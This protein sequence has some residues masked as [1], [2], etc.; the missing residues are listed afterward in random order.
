MDV[1]VITGLYEE[2]TALLDATPQC[3]WETKKDDRDF[4]YHVGWLPTGESPLGI[5]AAWAGSMGPEHAVDA[6]RALTGILRPQ[7]IAMCGI[8]AGREG[9]VFL[10]DVIV[11]NRVFRYDQ[12]KLNV[13]T[14]KGYE[15]EELLH[16]LETHNLKRSWRVDASYF[17]DEGLASELGELRP[18]SRLYQRTWVLDALLLAETDA[19]LHP[20][21]SP[22]RDRR[23]PRW[24]DVVMSLLD[25]DLCHVNELGH[26]GLTDSGRRIAQRERVVRP[27]GPRH[28]PSLRVHV[29]PIATGGTKRRDPG[30]F[31]RIS[32]LN[33]KVLGVEME[34][35]SIGLVAENS[36]LRSLVV[37]AVSD[38]GGDEPQEPEMRLF[39][40]TASARFLVAFLS[41]LLRSSR[42]SRRPSRQVNP[43]QDR[44]AKPSDLATV[45]GVPLPGNLLK[46]S[47]VVRGLAM[48]RFLHVPTHWGPAASSDRAK[49]ANVC[50]VLLGVDDLVLREPSAREAVQSGIDWLLTVE[51]DGAFPS[52]SRDLVTTQ[53]TALASIA[54]LGVSGCWR[55]SK[56]HRA[57]SATLA[58]RA[59]KAC[60]HLAGERGWGTWEGAS[61]RI[62][63]TLWALIALALQREAASAEW[64]GQV[65]AAHSLGSPGRFGFQPGTEPRISPT[66]SFLLLVS[67]S[68]AGGVVPADS[69][70]FGFELDSA[71]E[72]LLEAFRAEPWPSSEREVYYVDPQ[73]RGYVGNVEQWSW[74]HTSGAL[75]LA[76]LALHWDRVRERSDMELVTRAAATLC[77]RM[78][79]GWVRDPALDESGLPDAIFPTAYACAALRILE[80]V[81]RDGLGQVK[82]TVSS[83]K[84]HGS[85]I[86]KS[87]AAILKEGALLLVR[88][89]GTDKLIMPGG[90]MEPGE[91]AK[92]AL[93]R[94]LREELNTDVKV[95]GEAPLGV[96]RAAAA[97]ESGT[98][99][100]MT[101]FLCSIEGT[102]KPRAEIEEWVWYPLKAGRR[103]K[104][105]PIVANEIIP[106][107]LRSGLVAQ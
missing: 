66:A 70:R 62:Q 86:H 92:G 1:L 5:G 58:G 59:A 11:A 22:E 103:E 8:C 94:E 16:D 83:Y 13:T 53:C 47:M 33:R 48:K 68:E 52:L 78:E 14:E 76:A 91:S 54:A 26:L 9:D 61:V 69:D 18:V 72:L 51:R 87:G 32:R 35:A 46:R 44:V 57:K 10:G 42:P 49:V 79:I 24:A 105:S 7:V 25:L 55:L 38:Y 84:P 60:L 95:L 96:F 106:F 89:Y 45:D 21:H 4:P 19:S 88:K 50:E 36:D 104:L 31:K 102:P 80:R 34:G 75:A 90:A 12:G 77:A 97:F 99:I 74:L 67:A 17:A 81:T 100:E 15:T 37:K 23:C 41:R 27:A 64:L 6:A 29:G 85:V 39:A 98:V 3:G 56:R 2:L 71:V 65:R 40:A 107:L 20:M 82:K 73:L 63:P 93:V 101:L 28:E 43:N 30:L